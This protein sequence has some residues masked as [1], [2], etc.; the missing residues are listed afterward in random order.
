MEYI[1]S[2]LYE[3]DA[4]D[5]DEAT[6]GLCAQMVSVF[7]WIFNKPE[8]LFYTYIGML[9]CGY[10]NYLEYLLYAVSDGDMDICEI[11]DLFGDIR[12][13]RNI[14]TFGDLYDFCAAVSKSARKLN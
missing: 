1:Y 2:I 6:I 14:R 7:A 10:N 4:E 11:M 5:Y 3:V 9:K 8:I 12:E 13:A